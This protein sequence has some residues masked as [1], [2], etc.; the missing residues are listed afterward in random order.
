MKTVVLLCGSNC[1]GKTM[2]LKVF[3]GVKH[4]RKLKSM[5]L[6]ERHLDGKTVYAVSLCSPH[7]LANE[8]CNVEKVKERIEK[9]LKKCNEKAQGKDYFLTIPFTMSV[10]NG[11]VNE[12]CILEPIE[13]L[14]AMNIRVFPVYLRKTR[15]DFLDAK[16]ALMD[17]INATIIESKIGGED[18]QAKELEE[19]IKKL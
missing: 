4:I 9:R 6:L 2:T 16:D 7:E 18:R 11:K 8:F 10:K 14:R 12:K 3:F 1:A 5:Q 17:K 15:T 13:W 19:I